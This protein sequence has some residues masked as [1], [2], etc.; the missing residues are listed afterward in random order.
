MIYLDN[1]ATYYK[2]P[3]S[4]YADM[5]YYTAFLSANAGRGSH[6]LSL[7]ASEKIADTAYEIAGLFNI[8]NP[9]NIAFTSNAT[10]ALNMAVLGIGKNKHIVTT[11]MEHNSILRPVHKLGCCTIVKADRDGFVN[12]DKIY[13]AIRHNTGLVAVGHISNVC[14]SIQD[15][16]KISSICHTFKVPVLV[17]AAQSAGVVDIDVEK[18]NIDMLA[19]SGHKG[20]MGPLGT[21]GLY[22]KDS[23]LLEP[24]ITGGTGSSSESLSQPLVMPDMFQSGTMNTP[25]I[26][27][28]ASGVRFIKKHTP[29]AILEH[30][31]ALA[32]F[33]I[34]E[35]SNMDKI[36]LYG[37]RDMSNRNGTLIF[38][39]ENMSS[40]SVCEELSRIYGIITRGGWHCAYLAH[41]TIGSVLNGGVRVSPGFFNTKRDI[42]KL[43]DA[44]SKIRNEN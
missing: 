3:L 31:R 6:S 42:I 24:I 29:G 1:A 13:S 8:K 20:L 14:G 12:P 37:S 2:K 36:I 43:I 11:S 35:L 41:K 18:S 30:E 39:I 26:I 23:S 21:G 19:F 9:M 16:D 28:L 44:I 27:A 4:V 40:I 33:L 17:D 15:I 25:A 22:V 7:K 10:I 32:E 34:D 5:A 38:N